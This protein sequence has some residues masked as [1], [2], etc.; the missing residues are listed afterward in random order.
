MKEIYAQYGMIPD[1]GGDD[2]CSLQMTR[3]TPLCSS[4]LRRTGILAFYASYIGN[5]RDP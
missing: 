3:S 1:V 2:E 5:L 4:G